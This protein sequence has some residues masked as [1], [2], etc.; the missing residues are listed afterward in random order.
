MTTLDPTSWFD[1]E[2]FGAQL[3]SAR[4]LAGYKN[5]N[6]F[7]DAI[8]EV[9]DGAFAI[10]TGS[11]HNYESGKT[12]PSGD[13]LAAICTALAPEGQDG[14]CELCSE[15]L[16]YGMLGKGTERAA[17]A[18]KRD[19]VDHVR[20]MIK[21][22][23]D[24]EETDAQ[25]DGLTATLAQKDVNVAGVA[26]HMVALCDRQMAIF[27]SIRKEFADGLRAYKWLDGHYPEKI[28][29]SLVN[30]FEEGGTAWKLMEGV[31]ESEENIKKKRDCYREI[32]D[33]KACEML[34]EA[35]CRKNTN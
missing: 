12:M 8:K 15:L 7:S 14:A 4:K 1:R 3:R 18:V 20:L 16:R 23:D 26:T 35:V 31:D 2:E 5:L 27:S 33:E 21:A 9:T 17:D 24:L 22:I 32:A 28:P 19:I 34:A 13:V 29:P 25:S 11:L 6:G 30:V 10:A